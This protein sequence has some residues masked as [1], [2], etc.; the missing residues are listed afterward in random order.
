LAQKH[1]FV[2]RVSF[3]R[4]KQKGA[5][6][7]IFE[8]NVYICWR[9]LRTK[10]EFDGTRNEQWRWDYSSSKQIILDGNVSK[11]TCKL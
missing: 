11:L 8:A 6:N 2:R 10:L 9:P 7:P 3:G 5:V 1:R 4:Q